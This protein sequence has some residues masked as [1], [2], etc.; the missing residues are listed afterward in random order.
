[1]RNI[2]RYHW[3][4]T[5]LRCAICGGPFGFARHYVCRTALCSTKCT[6][7]FR[8]WRDDDRRWLHQAQTA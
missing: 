3:N 2:F 6:D 1:M 5:T 7:R 8:V 4:V